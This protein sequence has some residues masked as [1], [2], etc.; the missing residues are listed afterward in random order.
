MPWQNWPGGS[1]AP[2]REDEFF[3][4]VNRTP[5]ELFLICLEAHVPDGILCERERQALKLEGPFDFG[6]VGIL[7]SVAGPPP[8]VAG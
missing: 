8:N 3:L 7:L 2:R 6:Q 1:A 5:E 4:S